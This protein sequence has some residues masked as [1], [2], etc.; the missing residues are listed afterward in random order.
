MQ[1]VEMSAADRKR[2]AEARTLYWEDIVAKSPTHGAKLKAML[3]PY[4]H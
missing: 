2:L 1:V 3:E 4:S